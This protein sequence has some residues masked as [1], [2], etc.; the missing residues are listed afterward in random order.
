MRSN[1]DIFTWRHACTLRDLEFCCSLLLELLRRLICSQ[2]FIWNLVKCRRIWH[3]CLTWLIHSTLSSWASS[4]SSFCLRLNKTSTLDW[5]ISRQE[6]GAISTL[7]FLSDHASTL[8]SNKLCIWPVTTFQL[9]ENEHSFIAD[10]ECPNARNLLIVRTSFIIILNK[11]VVQIKVKVGF[12][13][14]I[15][16]DHGIWN[17]LNDCSRLSLEK[18]DVFCLIKPGVPCMLLGILATLDY[19]HRLFLLHKKDL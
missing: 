17:S 19:K 8:V 14:L 3:L 7:R 12:G 18:L 1:H 2:L 11:I 16:H 5:C 15:L 10:F 9:W 6:H 13:N 4:W